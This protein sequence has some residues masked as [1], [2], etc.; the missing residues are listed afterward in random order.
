MKTT[1]LSVFL[2]FTTLVSNGQWSYTNLSEPKGRMGTAVHGTK[3]YFAGGHNENGIVSEVQV[4]DVENEGWISTTLNLSV[5]RM[6]PSGVACG[7]KVLF[8]GG[9]NMFT[10][11]VFTEVDIFDTETNQWTLGQL[12][13]PRV[14]LSSVS[15][16]NIVLFAGGTNLSTSYDIVDIYDIDSDTWTIDILSEPRSSMGAAVIGD[17]AFFAG[18]FNEQTAAVSNVVD[19]YHFSTNTWTSATLSEARGYLTATAV[20]NKVLFAG[21][22]KGDNT[23]SDRVD[24]YDASTGYWS[25][26]SLSI[27]RA[28][29][30]ESTSA[31]V[32][33]KAY[34]TSGGHFDLYQHNWTSDFNVIDIYNLTDDTWTVDY[35]TQSLILQA[36]AGVDDHLIV[37]GGWN[38]GFVSNVE[39][40]IDPFCV[41][42]D[43]N[44]NPKGE[45]FLSVFPNPCNSI[46]T[47]NAPHG[48]MIEYAVIYNQT[49]QKVLQGKPMNNTL[50]ISNLHHGM[51]IIEIKTM[52]GNMR[53]KL[54]IE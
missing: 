38:Y 46:L 8:A 32:C 50:D 33:D 18:G 10:G 22:T 14:F 37:A 30:P 7:N 40:Y 9:A 24:I 45:T 6:H 28:L 16:G 42:T 26:A 12:V 17:L 2:V 39:I 25:T 44:S 36:V 51:Y 15:N 5:P 23:P 49:G 43:I 3:A 54:I 4:Y 31:T 34:F 21:G 19:I 11:A 27:P 35:L 20:G 41:N 48:G 29:F 13:I 47:M 52:E 1:L 53:N